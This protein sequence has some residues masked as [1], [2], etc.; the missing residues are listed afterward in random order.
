MKPALVLVDV[1]ADY[2]TSAGLQ[3]TSDDLMARLVPLREAC[4]QRR[5]PVFH[6][7]TTVR[8]DD[9]RRLPHWRK[10]D[11]WPCEAG[12]PGHATPEP[13]R[14]L[15]GETVIHKTGFNPFADGELEKSLRQAGCDT[16]ILAGLHLHACVRTAAVESLERG[17]RVCIAED[18]VATNDPILAA[19][20]RRWL[21]QRC[22]E[23]ESS[24]ALLAQLDGN[25]IPERLHRSPC[26]TAAVLFHVPQSSATEIAGAAQA[27]R[28]AWPAWRRIGCA[29]RI[30][31]IENLAALLETNAAG[32]ARK[33][34]L[35]IGKPIR[36]GAEE[37][38][39][40]ADN[41]R[42]VARRAAAES[43]EKQLSAGSVRYEPLGV[44]ATISAWNNPVAIPLGKIAP[45]LAYGNTVVWKPAPAAQRIAERLLQLLLAAGLPPDVVRVVGGDPRVA[46][47]L[48]ARDEVNAVTL[49]GSSTGGFA[50]AEVCTRRVIPFQAELSGNNAAIVWDDADLDLAAAQVAWGAFAF[51]GQRCTAN[52]RV[53][54]PA[55]LLE[56]FLSRLQVA[57]A[58]LP[59]GDPLDEATEIGPVIS[60][61]KRDELASSITRAKA[62]GAAQRV[63]FPHENHANEPWVQR[64]AFAPP[65]IVRCDRSE[66]PLVQEETMSP[67]LVVQPARDF[68]HALELCNGVR[69]GLA[70]ALF[71]KSQKLQQ[72]FLDEAQ[73]GILKLNSTTAGVDVTLPFGGW[74]ASGVGPPEHGE[75]DRLFYTRL[76]AVYG[77]SKPPST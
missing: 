42:D 23:F 10:A 21:A 76:Q 75:A 34:A 60:L 20:T 57:T 43:A 48:A 67:L 31:V 72:Q 28:A 54:V 77:F 68:N 30:P 14:P 59:W 27:A 47:E 45:A 41:L 52:R 62:S 25:A 8:R 33:M 44:I 3:P 74:K 26:D 1:Q 61:A 17:L 51:A 2:L 32:L 35:E 13:L 29:T 50:L 71:T 63:I 6:V 55:G 49:T 24:A 5:V 46:Q 66:H 73:A 56:N 36:H 12:T 70:A 11:R 69:H 7:W 16:V 19:A 37:V 22:V 53:I 18:A 39:R 65:V 38:R 64:G 4:R 40:T 58:R 9:D 15:A